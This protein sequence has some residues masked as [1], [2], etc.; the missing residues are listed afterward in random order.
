MVE[1]QLR[2]LG[3]RWQRSPEDGGFCAEFAARNGGGPQ[4]ISG[5]T[6]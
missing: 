5:I 6:G 3:R 2:L 1:S 4:W